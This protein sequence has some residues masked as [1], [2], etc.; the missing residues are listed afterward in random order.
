MLD[1]SLGQQYFSR[2]WLSTLYLILLSVSVASA[3][4][5]NAGDYTVQV[6]AVVTSFLPEEEL[7]KYGIEQDTDQALITV[8]IERKQDRAISVPANVEVTATNLLGQLRKIKMREIKE[9]NAAY[10]VGEFSIT[11]RETLDFDIKFR[12]QGSTDEHSV[13]YR[14]QFFTQ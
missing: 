12:P 1:S 5:L 8:M 3:E 6:N 13:K 14:K 7:Q 10:Y 11:H 4:A 2:Y 9:G